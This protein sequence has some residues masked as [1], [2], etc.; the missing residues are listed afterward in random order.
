MAEGVRT[1]NLPRRLVFLF[2]AVL[3][4]VVA[5]LLVSA[6]QRASTQPDQNQEGGRSRPSTGSVPAS[7]AVL[8]GL[9]AAGVAAVAIIATDRRERARLNEEARREIARQDHE[10]ELKQMELEDQR[11]S[12]LR[13]E[14][15]QAYFEFL[16]RWHS[17]EDARTRNPRNQ[18]EFEKANLAFQRSFNALS[19]IAPYEVRAAADAIRQEEVP[20]RRQEAS[21]APGRFW[22]A[23]RKDLGIPD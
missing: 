15:R 17:Y 7:V 6:M 9:A 12:R 16:A 5:G 14:R 11:Q 4:F 18:E 2:F 23:A 1:V 22:K 10:R 21:G 20:G 3:L 8:P 19:L 13:D